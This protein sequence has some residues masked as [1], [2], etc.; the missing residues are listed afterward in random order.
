L[1]DNYFQII[2]VKIWKPYP[3]ILSMQCREEG[4]G[5]E[6]KSLSDTEREIQ[7]GTC[8]GEDAATRWPVGRAEASA[9]VIEICAKS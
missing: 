5:L 8:R 4:N 9:W 7:Y 3:T 2:N 6:W 1:F